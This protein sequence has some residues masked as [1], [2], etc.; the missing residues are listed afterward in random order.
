MPSANTNLSHLP[1][2]RE[3]GTANSTGSES[4]VTGPLRDCPNVLTLFNQARMTNAPLNKRLAPT[5]DEAAFSVHVLGH[6]SAR[7]YGSNGRF[8]YPRRDSTSPLV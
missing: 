2:H 4:K 3:L 1:I 6:L 8:P 5:V 7:T